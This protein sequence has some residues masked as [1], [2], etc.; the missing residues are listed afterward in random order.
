MQPQ[1]SFAQS[2]GQPAF[3]FSDPTREYYSGF[4]YPIATGANDI[5]SPSSPVAMLPVWGFL[6]GIMRETPN[7]YYAK[8]GLCSPA[9]CDIAIRPSVIFVTLYN[10]PTLIRAIRLQRAQRVT[11]DRR[12]SSLVIYEP[13]VA[14]TPATSVNTTAELEAAAKA[15]GTL[16]MP[17]HCAQRLS[18]EPR[19]VLNIW[20]R[21]NGVYPSRS[22]CQGT[23]YI[24][25]VLDLEVRGRSHAPP[26]S[27]FDT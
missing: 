21:V 5:T 10:S 25:V 27:T 22:T 19:R 2:Q 7:G 4:E 14:V 3:E 18:D 24:E 8:N 17:L 6:S 12:R 26:S 11:L 16:R 23:P 13:S 15:V 1:S 20:P 9:H